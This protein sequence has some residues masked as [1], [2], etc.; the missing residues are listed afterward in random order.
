MYKASIVDEVCSLEHIKCKRNLLG[1]LHVCSKDDLKT[2]LNLLQ[3]LVV[4]LRCVE[5]AFSAAYFKAPFGLLATTFYSFLIELEPF[6][7]FRK[8]ISNTVCYSF[9]LSTGLTLQ[10]ETA[11]VAGTF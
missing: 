11:R 9:L 4:V 3:M 6:T 8:G 7:S 2:H 5:E 1:G 10:H